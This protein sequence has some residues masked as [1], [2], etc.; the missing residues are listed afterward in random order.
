MASVVVNKEVD[1][2]EFYNHLH[3]NLPGY[4]HPVFI[5]IQSA[6]PK[7]S[8]FK[9]QKV[10]LAQEGFNVHHVWLC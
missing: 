2:I 4:A 3:K 10:V 9:Y 1:W 6:I 7:T 8:T 5:R